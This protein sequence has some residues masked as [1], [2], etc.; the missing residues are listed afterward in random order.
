[1]QSGALIQLEEDF[2]IEKLDRCRYDR[3]YSH[4]VLKGV[5]QFEGSTLRVGDLDVK[6]AMALYERLV[7][8]PVIDEVNG[9]YRIVY[10][11]AIEAYSSK[12]YVATGLVLVDNLDNRP[13]V[14]DIINKGQNK[15]H[16][17]SNITLNTYKLSKDHEDQWTYGFADRMGRVQKGTVFGNSV[18]KDAVFGPEFE[19]CSSR[20]VGWYTDF[21]GMPI[22]VKVSPRGSVTLWSMVP[23]EVFLNFIRKEIVPY[24]I[25]L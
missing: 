12:I 25:S 17:A 11:D 24:I 14:K 20:S 8:R 1:M 7:Q 19:N 13:F 15:A 9:S 23:P 22:K 21:F 16:L 6:P 18:E 5:I 2:D 3:K 10:R 4:H